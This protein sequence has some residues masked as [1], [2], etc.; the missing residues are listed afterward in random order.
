MISSLAYI[1][2]QL[3]DIFIWV[4][5]IQ[6]IMSWLLAFNVL[7]GRNRGV[8]LIWNTLSRV[9]EP[10]IGPIRRRLPNFGGIDFAPLVLILVVIFV[11]RWLL[12]PLSQG[13]LPS[14]L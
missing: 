8:F 3:L 2:Y 4:L 12:L 13:Q 14:L 10:V 1:V 5:V 9:T 6:A 7:N 11:Q